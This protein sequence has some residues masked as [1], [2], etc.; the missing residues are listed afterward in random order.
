MTE[1]DSF[2]NEEPENDDEDDNQGML[3]DIQ[4]RINEMREPDE[5]QGGRPVDPDS[6]DIPEAIEKAL[7]KY[8]IQAEIAKKT[9]EKFDPNV[10]FFGT[11]VVNSNTKRMDNIR[12]LGEFDSARMARDIPYMRE[13][14]TD[15]KIRTTS[16]YQMCRSNP[17]VGGFDRKMQY[18]NIRRDSVD[19]K[20]NQTLN[21]GKSVKKGGGILGWILPGKKKDGA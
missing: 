18:T 7:I 17:E 1:D 8:Q 11:H 10:S 9:R 13:Y 3:V 4:K 19:V 15:I 2:S 16:E 6:M 20:Q 14:A 5:Q 21:Q 12:H